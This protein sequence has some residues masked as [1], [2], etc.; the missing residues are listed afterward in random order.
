MLKKHTLTPAQATALGWIDNPFAEPIPTIMVDQWGFERDEETGVIVLY[1]VDECKTKWG[2]EA[3]P[4]F[5]PSSYSTRPWS[6][7]SGGW[8]NVDKTLL[9]QAIN[10]CVRP[11]PEVGQMVYIPSMFRYVKVIEPIEGGFRYKY[12][13]DGRVLNWKGE[14]ETV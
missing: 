5:P 1:D 8:E 14:W 10:V 4:P 13:N 3:P 9:F 12:R 11:L 2:P 6:R 7:K